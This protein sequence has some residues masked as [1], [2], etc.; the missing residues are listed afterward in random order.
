[1]FTTFTIHDHFDADLIASVFNEFVRSHE[2]FHTAFDMSGDMR[3]AGRTLRPE[4]VSL[5]V[6][7]TSTDWPGLTVK[8]HL[9]THVPGLEEWAAFEFAVTGIEHARK[10]VETPHFEVIIAADH[11]FTD[12]VSQAVSFFEIVSRYSAARDGVGFVG[13]PVRPYPEFCAEQRAGA[14][15]LTLEHAAVQ[16]WREVIGRAGGM[17]EF[18]LPLGLGPGEAAAGRILVHSSFVDSE[19]ASLFATAAKQAGA[20]TGSA[21][22]ALLGQVHYELSGE[23]LFTMLVPRADRS[24]PGDAMAVGWYV[25]LVPVQFDA[26][27]SFEEVAAAAHA[28]MQVAR[29]LERVPVFPVIDLLADDPSF[30]VDHG[31]AAPML[32]YVDVARVP[33]AELARRHDFSVYANATPSREVFMWI[34]RDE[35]GL[36]FNAT[37]PDTEA[38]GRA[39]DTVFRS[40][41]EKIIDVATWN[42]GSPL[43]GS[44]L[45]VSAQTETVGTLL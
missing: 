25:T 14:E 12:G 37:H 43:I 1:M 7:A 4:Q 44:Q 13:V 41:R 27:G 31:F 35:A 36:D 26:R 20:N 10:D 24:A 29:Q 42:V 34:N 16:Q 33:G 17:P 30:P 21:L 28:A 40:L 3:P 32:S 11:M 19:T 38:A 22:L 8:D 15:A 5:A 23:G 2:S 6:A 18:P 39:V 9:M 45:S